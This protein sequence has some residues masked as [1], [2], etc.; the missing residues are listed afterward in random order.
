MS[1]KGK[2]SRTRGHR[3]SFTAF[4]LLAPL[5]LLL[6]NCPL[7]RSCEIEL[8]S[9]SRQTKQLSTLLPTGGREGPWQHN[10][11]PMSDPDKFT[12]CWKENKSGG[13][14]SKVQWSSWIDRGG[15]KRLSRFCAL[16]R[17]FPKSGPSSGA[18]GINIDLFQF[19]YVKCQLQYVTS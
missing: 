1:T 2:K 10:N 19:L 12:N 8:L 14:K 13:L 4:Q 7:R 15:G 5:S 18:R 16:P 9:T 6:S 3:M 17:Y 11:T